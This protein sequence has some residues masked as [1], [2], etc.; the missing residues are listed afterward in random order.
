MNSRNN[1]PL[2]PGERDPGP[3]RGLAGYLVDNNN[4]NLRV[5]DPHNLERLRD[6]VF[7]RSCDAAPLAELWTANLLGVIAPRLDDFGCNG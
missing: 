3:S 6:L 5:V 1:R 7:S 2:A 4:I